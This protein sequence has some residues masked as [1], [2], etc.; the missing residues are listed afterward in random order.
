MPEEFG[1]F[2]TDAKTFDESFVFLMISSF[3]C[4]HS[5]LSY[6]Q[7]PKS[8]PSSLQDPA[9]SCS[10]VI[11]HSLSWVF[12]T[13]HQKNVSLY[14]PHVPLSPNFICYLNYIDLQTVISQILN[15]AGGLF[16][17]FFSNIKIDFR[18]AWYLERNLGMIHY[19]SFTNLNKFMVKSITWRSQWNIK[20]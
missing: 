13:L 12:K 6:H 1:C 19:P 9:S 5:P 16:G 3:S 2:W 7:W 15:L 17:N 4:G 18:F 11:I 20:H 14:V 8:G 10:I